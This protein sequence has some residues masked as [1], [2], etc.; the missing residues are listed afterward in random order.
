MI[1]FILGML[2]GATLIAVP[3]ILLL[4]MVCHPGCMVEDYWDKNSPYYHEYHQ[5]QQGDPSGE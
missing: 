1:T 5:S 4:W 2:T 3:V